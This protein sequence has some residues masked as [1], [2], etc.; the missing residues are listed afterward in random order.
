L[1]QPDLRKILL[2]AQRDYLAAIRTKAFLVS[3][4]VR[5]I[6]F[7]GGFL[8][9]ALNNRKPDVQLRRIAIVDQ[10]GTAAEPVVEAI[11]ARNVRDLR[12]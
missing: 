3:L 5:P 10:T 6:L 9:A 4:L 8:A 2:I 1:P 11:R 7:G 12:G